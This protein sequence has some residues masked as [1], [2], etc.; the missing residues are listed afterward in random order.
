MHT[1]RLFTFAL[2]LA[3]SAHAAASDFVS[4]PHPT[5]FRG[6]EWGVD[7]KDVSDLL[8][9]QDAGFKGTYF[10]KNESMTLGE[11]ELVS[12][13][14][15][16]KKDKLYRVGVAFEGR[17]N[18]FFLKDMLIEKYGPGRGIGFRYGWMWPDF[19]IELNY[20]NDKES[21]SL[22]YTFEGEVQ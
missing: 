15:Y 11:A 2:V 8:P 16:F 12:V 13:A 7:L 18:Q 19:S 9:V 4:V 6:L 22:Y 5:S 17:T 10:K 14:Y 21:G 3:V 20:D 1:L